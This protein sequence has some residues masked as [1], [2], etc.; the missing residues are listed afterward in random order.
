MTEV[1]K[2]SFFRFKK[3]RLFIILCVAIAIVLITATAILSARL[4]SGIQGSEFTDEYRDYLLYEKELYQTALANPDLNDNER[5]KTEMALAQVEYYLE[6]QTTRDDYYNEMPSDGGAYWMQVYFLFGAVASAIASII[7][8][9][10][11]FPG[12][13]SGVHRTE[14]LTGRTRSVLWTGKNTASL[15]VSITVPLVF[16]LA[17]LISALCAYDARFLVEDDLTTKVYSVSIFTQWA[18]QSVSLCVIALISA[19]LTSFVTTLS[20]DSTVGGTV[21]LVVLLLFTLGMFIAFNI[22]KDNAPDNLISTFI[23]YVGIMIIPFRYGVTSAFAIALSVYIFVA[24]I[25]FVL[26]YLIYRRKVL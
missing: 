21:P 23:P 7:V 13:K 2:V 15:L 1:F 6:T 25:L 5:H 26:S 10:F 8:S 3:S 14:F 18:L 4:G 19:A 9:V 12:T 16:I 11:F 24:V 17:M 22:F 20:G